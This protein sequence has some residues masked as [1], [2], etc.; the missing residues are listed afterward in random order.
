[1]RPCLP[2]QK[3]DRVDNSATLYCLK[4]SGVTFFVVA[5]SA[6][7]F[8]PLSQNSTKDRSPSGSGQAQ[9]EQSM[10]PFWLTLSITRAPRTM[11][12]ALKTCLAELTTAGRPAAVCLTVPTRRVP[13]SSGDSVRMGA[14]PWTPWPVVSSAALV[15]FDIGSPPAADSLE[16]GK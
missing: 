1:M 8:A 16:Q 3:S 9:L 15:E 14:L 5:S 2:S 13:D 12:I 7:A 6:I 10:P 4:N 11:P